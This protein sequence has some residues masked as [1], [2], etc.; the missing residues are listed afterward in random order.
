MFA[1]AIIVI[2]LIIF[3]SKSSKGTIT[4]SG[5]VMDNTSGIGALSGQSDNFFTGSAIATTDLR[6]SGKLTSTTT[7]GDT[8]Y[9]QVFKTDYNETSKTLLAQVLHSDKD[10]YAVSG[11]KPSS[12]PQQI[13]ITQTGSSAPVLLD[14]TQGT[15]NILDAKF[16]STGGVVL[17][18]NDGSNTNNLYLYSNDLKQLATNISDNQI[19]GVLGSS[20][21]TREQT[22]KTNI[23]PLS[24][25]KAWS[26]DSGSDKVL[27]DKTTNTIIWLQGKKLHLYG[28]DQ[29]RKDVGLDE[30]TLF[31]SRGNVVALDSATSPKRMSVIDI[32][33][34][35]TR[36]FGV[37]FT[38]EAITEAIQG[39]VM[40]DSTTPTIGLVTDSSSLLIASSNQDVVKN[41]TPYKFPVFTDFN[42]INYDV[43][44]GQATIFSTDVPGSLTK[45]AADCD[46]DLNQIRK[47][48]QKPSDPNP[49]QPAQDME[50]PEEDY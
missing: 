50:V 5:V 16:T 44:S 47:L 1:A 31:T 25:G 35:K 21:V 14:P 20:V 23:S 22:G 37:S 9:T 39:V 29:K 34:R 32:A 27:I 3:S 10:L 40:V 33:T 46:C 11:L 15:K 12:G 8:P 43:G 2:F 45:L 17:L 26:L 19:V 28:E 18:A 49:Y 41:V 30:S 48:W 4:V 42:L 7:T 13:W 38:N 36:T 6:K 24:G